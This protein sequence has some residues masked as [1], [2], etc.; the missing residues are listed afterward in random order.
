[1]TE[2]VH[3]FAYFTH[4]GQ[5]GMRLAASED[6]LN[7]KDIPGTDYLIAPEEGLMRDPFLLRAVDKTFHLIW[8]TDWESREIGYASSRDLVNWSSQKRLPMMNAFPSTRNCWAPEMVYDPSI[9]KYRI[10]WASTVPERFPSSEGKS[11]SDYNHRMWT[12]T[13]PD[14]E[15][16]SDPEIFFDPGFN[17]IDITLHETPDGK[18]RLIGKD[19][20]LDPE[21][22]DLFVCDA[23]GFG[24]PFSQPSES[25]TDSWVEGPTCLQLGDWTHVYYDVYREKRYEGKR[26]KDFKKWEDISDQLSF[27]DGA[28]HGSMITVTQKDFEQLFE[29]K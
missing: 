22:K 18:V 1:M 2:F 7:W 5:Y 6:G 26:T 3:L 21:K 14:F 28:R 17:V 25:F 27:P 11:E 13:T 19:E 29:S 4:N 23:K 9:K 12:V 24:G 16:F 20:R 10:Y 15:M 8:T